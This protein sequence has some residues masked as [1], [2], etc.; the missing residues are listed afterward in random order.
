MDIVLGSAQPSRSYA[1]AMD[2]ISSDMQSSRGYTSTMDIAKWNIDYLIDAC[3]T[4][5]LVIPQFQRRRDWSLQQENELIET[6][7]FNNISIGVLQLYKLNGNRFLLIDGL[8][9]VT[10]LGKYY[11]NPYAFEVAKTATSKIRA[12]MIKIYGKTYDSDS[13][14]KICDGWFCFDN[15]GSYA[16]I[17]LYKSSEKRPDTSKSLEKIVSF[18]ADRKSKTIHDLKKFILSKT[19]EFA[20]SLCISDS[21]IPVIFNAGDESILPLLYK[22]INQ[23]GT[24]LTACDVLASSWYLG[25]KITV[26]NKK[27][28]TY[29]QKHYEDMKQENNNMD[30]YSKPNEGPGCVVYT[31]YE[32]IIG[33]KKYIFDKYS[34]TFLQYITDKEYMFKLLSCCFFND[35]SKPSIAKLKEKII[36]ICEPSDR[37]ELDILEKKLVRCFDFVTEI[38]DP[39][40]VFDAIFSTKEIGEKHKTKLLIKEIPFLV[41][42]TT[43]VYKCLDQIEKSKNYYKKLF[44]M[45]ILFDVLSDTNHNIKNLKAMVINKKYLSKIDKQK[46]CN[47]FDEFVN[48]QIENPLNNDRICNKTQMILLV[49]KLINSDNDGCEYTYISHIV[50]KNKLDEYNKECVENGLNMVSVNSLGNL[51]LYSDDDDNDKK[52]KDALYKYFENN[53]MSEEYIYNNI[54]CLGND[55]DYGEYNDL[56]QQQEVSEKQYNDFLRLRCNQIKQNITEKYSDC[57]VNVNSNANANVSNTNID[58]VKK[59]CEKNLD[60][61]VLDDTKM[62][63]IKFKINKSNKKLLY[64]N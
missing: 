39:I 59:V 30:I 22:R 23:N 43:L 52:I 26:N 49:N 32:Y 51:C 53:N 3:D 1:S 29:I 55:V 45:H 31:V 62:T 13:L 19:R 46:F 15:L 47:Y 60:D 38:L 18:I 44:I 4:K 17:M 6:L 24:P 11:R 50:L 10:T 20:L 42:F 25:D 2:T 8:H 21:I 33:L 28:V 35:I 57:F 63:P 16:N 37:D 48:S 27:I 41:A 36:E 14:K 40:I 56:V 5:K 61:V 64:K 12:E 9:R 7:K 58:E 34:N 54:I